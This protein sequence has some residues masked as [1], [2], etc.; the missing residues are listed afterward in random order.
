MVS[1]MHACGIYDDNLPT[2]IRTAVLF[3]LGSRLHPEQVSTLPTA[4][5]N[6]LIGHLINNS[7]PL[8]ALLIAHEIGSSP[9]ALL[10]LPRFNNTA[11]AQEAITE[12]D[13]FAYTLLG[14]SS[15]AVTSD[16]ILTTA[17][18]V[19]LQ[20]LASFDTAR[21]VRS[22]PQ[23]PVQ[24][25]IQWIYDKSTRLIL[26][27]NSS[28]H[29]ELAIDKIQ[30]LQEYLDVAVDAQQINLLRILGSLSSTDHQPAFEVLR[31][32]PALAERQLVLS[33]MTD[34]VSLGRLSIAEITPLAE[35]V[36]RH[37]SVAA[38]ESIFLTRLRAL[39]HASSELSHLVVLSL[40]PERIADAS[41]L[42][43]T[44]RL[45]AILDGMIDRRT[46]PTSEQV[47]TL[48]ELLEAAS[49]QQE[50]EFRVGMSFL[51][52]EMANHDVSLTA[53]LRRSV[54]LPNQFVSCFL[55]PK[56]LQH[57][58]DL[59]LI[60]LDLVQSYP[61]AA[62]QFNAEGSFDEDLR[63]LIRRM[64]NDTLQVY[65]L[66]AQMHDAEAQAYELIRQGIELDTFEQVFDRV[67]HSELYNALAMHYLEVARSGYMRSLSIQDVQLAYQLSP[68]VLVTNEPRILA[69]ANHYASQDQLDQAFT[70]FNGT[71]KRNATIEWIA[72]HLDERIF[73]GKFEQDAP[74][75]VQ[76]AD[77]LFSNASSRLFSADHEARLNIINILPDQGMREG[78]LIEKADYY[79]SQ[80]VSRARLNDT[81]ALWE[82]LSEQKKASLNVHRKA[83]FAQLLNTEAGNKYADSQ[84]AQIRDKSP[85]E[86]TTPEWQTIKTAYAE[87][88]NCLLMA[89][90]AAPDDT[91]IL[92]E[93]ICY[94]RLMGNLGLSRLEALTPTTAN[95]A[96]RRTVLDRAV[97]R[98][99]NAISELIS[100]L[101]TSAQAERRL[102]NRFI[103]RTKYHQLEHAIEELISLMN[104]GEDNPAL[105][106][107]ISALSNEIQVLLLPFVPTDP[108]V[109]VMLA[110]VH[111]LQG[112]VSERH[113]ETAPVYDKLELVHGTEWSSMRPSR[114]CFGL[115]AQLDPTNPWYIGLTE[116]VNSSR[117][118]AS[119][120]RLLGD[121]QDW[122]D[123]TRSG[124]LWTERSAERMS[125][126]RAVTVD[127][128][129]SHERLEPEAQRGLFLPLFSSARNTAASVSQSYD[130]RTAV[131]EIMKPLR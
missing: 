16:T 129:A 118:S 108:E 70:L 74:L 92:E 37:L 62:D 124:I 65:K 18:G 75:R 88:L 122:N 94:H 50:R 55:L 4:I 116:G 111:Y 83:S 54:R 5:Q 95:F 127:S 106:H 27:R 126:F 102:S 23:V 29:C 52:T 45:H 97:L 26:D 72:Q 42:M 69:L 15:A 19:A 121:F 84:I 90:E 112:R 39:H 31:Q 113:W 115:A 76:V 128:Q 44:A 67:T 53:Q 60:F 58:R 41:H 28:A 63:M 34:L 101:P 32:N 89:H 66:C 110:N 93:L 14:H 13:D 120:S 99:L 33:M 104:E 79:F 11:L 20:H 86:R 10:A 17:L 119:A 103:A 40:G 51:A 96:L 123:L 73:N 81:K 56:I 48:L 98:H 3:Q 35:D 9:Q 25:I 130:A 100:S 2:H 78:F 38:L 8:D 24:D 46:L 125:L 12:R 114:R 91:D 21:F 36:F 71:L 7:R 61:E 22:V 77:K 109:R 85:R 105:L 30:A 47:A 59:P 57:P 1:E 49:R 107:S 6:D 87:S 80:Y 68:E 131:S 43:F 117:L 82:T 64:P